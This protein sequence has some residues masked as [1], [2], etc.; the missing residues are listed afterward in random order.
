MATQ[1]PTRSFAHC[2]GCDRD[3]EH[4]TRY[5]G[6]PVLCVDCALDREGALAMLLR[7]WFA[8]SENARIEALA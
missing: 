6:G 8:G 2:L 7:L 3:L 1:A 5:R 4:P